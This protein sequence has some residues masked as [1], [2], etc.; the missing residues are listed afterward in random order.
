MTD[1]PAFTVNPFAR[2]TIS[3]P[4][5]TVTLVAPSEA[6]AVIEIGTVRLVRVANVGA[7]AVTAPLANV[8]TD[9]VLKWVKFPVI[10]T[11]TLLA[12]C[13]PL[14]GFIRVITGVPGF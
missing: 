12:P 13:W 3:A 9:E 6:A 7:A 8:T 5:V 1:V 11:G 4:V 14:L 10:V 2:V